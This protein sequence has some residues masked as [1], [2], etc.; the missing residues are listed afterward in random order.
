MPEKNKLAVVLE[1]NKLDPT[2]TQ[3][4]QKVFSPFFDQV[5]KMKEACNDIVITSVDQVEDMQ[6]AREYRLVL[7][8]IRVAGGKEKDKLK[9]IPLRKCQAIDA[10][11]RYLKAEIEPLEKH[12][13]EQE[14]FME[15]EQARIKDELEDKRKEELTEYCADHEF[16]DLREMPEENYQK[17]LESAKKAHKLQMDA[18]KKEEEDRLAQEETDRKERERAEVENKKLRADAAKRDKEIEADRKK[19][20]AKKKIEDEK[21]K[22][23]QAEQDAI[24]EKERQ[25]RK[26]AEAKQEAV[27]AK[28]KQQREKA[29]ADLREKE[30]AEVKAK[31]DLAEKKRQAALAPDKEKL[32]N[33][34]VEVTKVQMP[35]VESEEA[36]KILKGCVELLN[37]TSNYIKEKTLNL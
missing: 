36:K 11:N 26:A 17:F 6:K 13:K 3:D 14:K 30:E 28:E 23:D 9:E 31:E 22:K 25:D 8:K 27:L 15:L 29:E 1:E 7:Q 32:Q 20:D 5:E 18:E 19:A 16:V 34:A 33:L 10:F 2:E 24:L 35:D 21:R 4:E 12:L 37:R